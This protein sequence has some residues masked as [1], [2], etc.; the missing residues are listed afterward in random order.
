MGLATKLSKLKVILRRVCK[1]PETIEID[2]DE[3]ELPSFSANLMSDDPYSILLVELFDA[4]Q[5]E[6]LK[7]CDMYGL[8]CLRG[9]NQIVAALNSKNRSLIIKLPSSRVKYLIAEG[10][11][12]PFSPVGHIHPEWIEILHMEPRLWVELI[13]EASR[14]NRASQAF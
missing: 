7:R 12:Q 6:E 4:L 13:R 2:F 11:G 1:K 5:I 14:F 10:W 3:S 9:N 8:P